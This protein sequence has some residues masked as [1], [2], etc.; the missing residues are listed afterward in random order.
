MVRVFAGWLQGFDARTEVPPRALTTSRPRRT[1][2]YIYKDDQLAAI[3]V[4]AA[5]LRSSYGLRDWTCS[6]LFGLIAVTGLRVNET[7]STKRMPIS[8]KRADGPRREES[9]EPFR[10]DLA[11]CN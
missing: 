5:R 10:S 2:P 3:V 8:S 4:E 9:Q 6:T 1:R 11:L 7:L